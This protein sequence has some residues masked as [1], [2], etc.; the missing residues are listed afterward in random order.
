M[1]TGCDMNQQLVAEISLIYPAD[2]V[3]CRCIGVATVPR[4]FRRVHLISLQLQQV[5]WHSRN[6]ELHLQYKYL[7]W[8]LLYISLVGAMG[9]VSQQDQGC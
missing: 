1:Q 8:K 3:W 2:T 4:Y 6:T 7:T 9:N 5:P